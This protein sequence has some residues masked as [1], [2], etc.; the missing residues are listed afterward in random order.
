MQLRCISTRD[1]ARISVSAT[2][3]WHIRLDQ[4]LRS[5]WSKS[6]PRRLSGP[7][8]GVCVHNRVESQATN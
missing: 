4:H 2:A 1:A 3:E 8:G 6:T 7:I 5:W